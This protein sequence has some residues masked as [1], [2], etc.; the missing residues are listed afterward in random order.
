MSPESVGCDAH[1]VFWGI[2]FTG[3][4]SRG[5]FFCGEDVRGLCSG[6]YFRELFLTDEVSRSGIVQGGRSDLLVHTRTQTDRQSHRQTDLN[7]YILTAQA[8]ELKI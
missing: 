5:I 2:F 8:A 3:K 6:K 1:L 4:L 7:G